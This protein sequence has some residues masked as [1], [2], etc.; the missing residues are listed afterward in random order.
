MSSPQQPA[1]QAGPS[2]GPAPATAPV[3]EPPRPDVYRSTM[4][5]VVWWVWVAFALANLADI[6]VQGRDHFAAEIAAVLILIT[7]VAYIAAF[8]PRVIADDAGITIENPLRDHRVPWACV[9]S[10][11]LRDSLQVRCSWHD[12]EQRSKLLYGWAVQS[13][14]RSR[15]RAEVR[16][17][18]N[19]RRT[20][21]RQPASYARLPEEA[22]QALAKTDAEHI[23]TAL[24]QRAERA[25]AAGAADATSAAG[26]RPVASWS[27]PSPRCC[28]PCCC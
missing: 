2:G 6:A 25:R 9:Q 7:G 16:A 10:V 5:L 20:A 15:L 18:R 28:S 22:K 3:G 17:Q 13:A 24:R 21:A 27:R 4:A 1:G 12:G 14:R 8:R 19:A 26:A 23:A 11:D